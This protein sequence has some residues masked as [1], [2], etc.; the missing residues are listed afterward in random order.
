[1]GRAPGL[2]V[3]LQAICGMMDCLRPRSCCAL[4]RFYKPDQGGIYLNGKPAADFTRGE[5]SKAV[6]LVSVD[7]L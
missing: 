1:M 3:W 7:S 6:A 2:C 5:W 4:L